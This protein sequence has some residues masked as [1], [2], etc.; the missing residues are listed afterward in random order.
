MFQGHFQD[1]LFG[2][3]FPGNKIPD[4]FSHCKEV[5]NKSECEICINE[6]SHLDGKIKGL[7][8]CAVL[9]VKDGRA[10]TPIVCSIEIIS[11]GSPSYGDSKAFNLS[12]SDHVWLLYHVPE[13]YEIKGDNLQVKFWCSTSLASFRCGAHLVRTRSDTAPSACI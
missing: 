11:N 9:G 3:V 13:Y 2:I 12:G 1:H 7:A 6:P 5:S 10:P 4:C 8:L